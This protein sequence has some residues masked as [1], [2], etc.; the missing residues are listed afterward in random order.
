MMIKYRVQRGVVTLP[1]HI[2]PSN[3][4]VAAG[5]TFEL[6]ESIND[7]F[8]RRSVAN[9]DITIEQA[10]TEQKGARK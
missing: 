3:M 1:A 9:G 7:R 10:V 4:R 6:D 2:S 8:L 5:E